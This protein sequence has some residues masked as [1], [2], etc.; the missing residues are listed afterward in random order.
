MNKILLFLLMYCLSGM[1]TCIAQF[2]DSVHHN[3]GYSATG[4]INQTNDGNSFVLNNNA[5][6]NVHKKNKY[7]NSSAGWVYGKQNAV[8]TNNDITA[9]MDFNIY[10][11]LPRLYYWGL[12]GY[13]KSYSL[14]INDR[15]QGGVGLG[16]NLLDKKTSAIVI[17]DGILYEYSDLED[18]IAHDTY[19]TFRNS[20]RLKYHFVFNTFIV[21]DGTHFWQPSLSDGNDYILKSVNSLSLKLRKWL[22]LTSSLIY[23]KVNR[24]QSKNLLFTI[25]LSADYYF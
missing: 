7:F 9:V 5:K 25:G 23:N 22:N 8:L 20:F 18:S 21:L 12:A 4:I 17:S 2:N 13:D 6:F 16:Y 14:K 11:K 19:H 24:T 15:F 3:F 1:E 10:G